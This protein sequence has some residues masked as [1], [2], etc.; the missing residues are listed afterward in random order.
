[1]FLYLLIFKETYGEA[2]SDSSEDEDWS[3]KS[4]LKKGRKDDGEDSVESPQSTENQKRSRR[5]KG[6][7]KEDRSDLSTPSR[8]RQYG[9]VF[10]QVLQFECPRFFLLML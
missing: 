6:K 8:E 10:S 4:I 7:Q 3:E 2:S 5:V 9:R 1:M